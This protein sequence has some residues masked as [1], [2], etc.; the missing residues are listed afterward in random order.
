[1]TDNT[2]AKLSYLRQDA[3]DALRTYINLLFGAKGHANLAALGYINAQAKFTL[4][5][6]EA[7]QGDILP[8]VELPND[9]S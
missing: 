3:A 7:K 9:A 6:L 8:Y 2:H 5:C 1:L 4:A